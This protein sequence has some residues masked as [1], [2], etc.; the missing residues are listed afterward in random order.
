MW[1]IPVLLC[2]IMLVGFGASLSI[3]T[4][5]KNHSR[6]ISRLQTSHADETTRLQRIYSDE[7][8]RLE[9]GH[10]RE[11]SILQTTTDALVESAY[12]S[13]RAS[14]RPHVFKGEEQT[15]SWFWKTK[16][17]LAIA[18]VLDENGNVLAFAGDGTKIHSVEMPPE[19]KKAIAALSGP[20]GKAL[21]SVVV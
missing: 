20:V 18:V 14:A 6:E 4:Q 15:G 13:G 11:I 1:S 17:D 19:I 21:A 7:L 16:H 2:V 9:A 10:A 12:R 5:R 8:T 3:W